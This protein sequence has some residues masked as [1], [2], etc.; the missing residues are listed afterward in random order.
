[1]KGAQLFKDNEYEVYMKP[2]KQIIASFLHEYTLPPITKITPF[3]RGWVNYNYKIETK[4][5]IYVLQI[6]GKV[7]NERKK[8][9]MDQMF[10]ALHTLQKE[11][12]PYEVP[13]PI[14]NK[15]GK[16]LTFYKERGAW[17]YPYLKGEQRSSLTRGQLQEI[18]RA[19]GQM[20][21]ILR[22]IKGK[23]EKDL[24]DYSGQLQKIQ[25][26]EE[27]TPHDKAQRY[28]QKQATLLRTYYN[29]LREYTF[30][31]EGMLCHA[32]LNMDNL[33]FEGRKLKGI[34]DFDNM[35]E[36]PRIQ[37]IAS[38]Y[39]KLIY[40]NKKGRKEERKVLKAYE[41]RISLTKEERKLIVPFIMRDTCGIIIWLYKNKK[42]STTERIKSAQQYMEILKRCF[43]RISS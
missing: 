38:A 21:Y 30:T 32:D 3:T 35:C 4:K 24:N 18:G 15:K 9:K 13:Q 11:K 40:V 19:I 37:N 36:G 22:R 33:L 12:F 14:Y 20:D 6:L 7:V 10:R 28:I 43:K 27:S 39:N 42:G 2:T 26:I 1:M 8:E 25:E 17:I 5:G 31:N 34:L 41:S 29:K 23:G 16:T